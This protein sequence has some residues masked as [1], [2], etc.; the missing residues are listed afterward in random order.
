[1]EPNYQPTQPVTAGTPTPS[2]TPPAQQFTPEI[3]PQSSKK[4]WLLIGGIAGGVVLIATLAVG[5]TI[6]GNNQ[7]DSY[8]KKTVVYQRSLTT[9]YKALS[10]T[11]GDTDE[12]IAYLDEHTAKFNVTLAEKPEDKSLLWIKA[13]KPAD[14]A[15]VDSLTKAATEFRTAMAEY[16]VFLAYRNG[17]LEAVKS[18][19]GT[20]RTVDEL[21]ATQTRI[22]KTQQSIRSLKAPKGLEQH[23]KEKADSYNAPLA[24]IK[25]ALA[26]YDKGDANG[27]A[28]AVYT[29]SEDVKNVDSLTTAAK[30]LLDMHQYYDAFSDRY[31]ELEKL[32]T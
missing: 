15:K 12:Y 8:A 17:F 22:E 24:D 13:A 25:Q 18:S 30:E 4:K 27:Y 5:G 16:R 29:L 3:T 32:L 14:K 31:D 20:I 9:A 2:S 26:A 21:R 23:Q 6:W 10:E 19:T 11:P 28:D 7:A 1:M